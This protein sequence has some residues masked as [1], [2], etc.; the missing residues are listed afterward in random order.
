MDSFD[1]SIKSLVTD[2]KTGEVTGFRLNGLSGYF[3]F[4]KPEYRD[5]KWDAPIVGGVF[6]IGVSP[7]DPAA[8]GTRRYWVKKLERLDED[9]P[10]LSTPEGIPWDDEVSGGPAVE[11]P[12]AVQRVRDSE[13]YRDDAISRQVALKC[14]ADVVVAAL[15]YFALDATGKV[16]HVGTGELATLIDA[17]IER[18]RLGLD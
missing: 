11:H 9:D 12:K 4:S 1:E 8:D 13:H 5:A 14:A 15:P 3:D 17:A 2:K 16:Q 10:D 6:R 7:R 18:F